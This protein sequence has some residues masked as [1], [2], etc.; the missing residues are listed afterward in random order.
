[1]N[2]KNHIPSSAFAMGVSNKKANNIILIFF[3]KND[4]MIY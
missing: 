3:I 2:I 1:M 4:I